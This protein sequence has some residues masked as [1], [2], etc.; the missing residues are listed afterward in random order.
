MIP[1]L[2]TAALMLLGSFS[3]A[4]N[5]EQFRIG[6]GT[7]YADSELNNYFDTYPGR[8]CNTR[9]IRVSVLGRP[10]PWNDGDVRI[11]RVYLAF[12]YRTEMGPFAGYIPFN[13]TLE[14]GQSTAW[15]QLPRNWGCL[16]RVRVYAQEAYGDSWNPGEWRRVVVTGLR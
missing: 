11:G 6:A 9:A 10:S 13:V 3:F 14:P 15:V 12:D 8:F 7:V 2:L 4:T 5:A 16:R 1:R